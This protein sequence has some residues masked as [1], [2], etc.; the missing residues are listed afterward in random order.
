MIG[1]CYMRIDDEQL[2]NIEKKKKRSKAFGDSIVL[3]S[4]LKNIHELIEISA[5][6][7]ITEMAR[8][9]NSIDRWMLSRSKKKSK[10]RCPP[11]TIIEVEFGLPFKG[12][13]PYRHSAMVIH[14]YESKVLV[15]PTTSNKDLWEKAYHPISNPDGSKE[16]YRVDKTDGFDH[17]CILSLVECKSISKNRIIE[18]YGIVDTKS[19]ESVYRQIKKILFYEI[20]PDEIQEYKNQIKE[21]E[22][23]ID[24]NKQTIANK[25]K[26]IKEL[27]S[28]INRYKKKL[29]G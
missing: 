2:K 1:E 8:F 17:N 18:T 13:T 23:E 10:R 3:S 27:Y 25:N 14:E 5:K 6:M 4:F 15:S 24:N 28:K 26:K 19:E 21:L 29:Y 20:F 7:S 12:E 16:F 22:K 9:S 11:G